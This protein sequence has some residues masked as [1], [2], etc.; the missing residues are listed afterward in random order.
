MGNVTSLTLSLLQGRTEYVLSQITHMLQG[1]TQYVLKYSLCM[2]TY[3]HRKNN[4]TAFNKTYKGLVTEN[5]FG[6]KYMTLK[7]L[8]FVTCYF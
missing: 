3:A 1:R 8:I 5:T 7:L 4:Y 6:E 2:K